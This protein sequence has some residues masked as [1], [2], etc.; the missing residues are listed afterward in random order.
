MIKDLRNNKLG[1][2][3]LVFL[4]YKVLFSNFMLLLLSFLFYISSK[5]L[6]PYTFIAYNPF[7]FLFITMVLE[8]TYF[9][10]TK[11][12]LKRVIVFL[13]IILFLSFIIFPYIFL[14]LPFLVLLRNLD[15]KSNMFLGSK[16]TMSN[17][18]KLLIV[19][20]LQTII[21]AGIMV[22]VI[23]VIIWMRRWSSLLSLKAE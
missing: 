17:I 9:K 7:I 3:K 18:G 6:T 11:Y 8:Y 23:F 1:I 22:G 4:T 13:M 15:M 12:D 5:F 21:I 19:N 16:L 10:R 20:L 2:F 14:L